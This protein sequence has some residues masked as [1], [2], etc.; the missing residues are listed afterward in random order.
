MADGSILGQQA[1]TLASGNT[2]TRPGTPVIGML[3]YNTQ[4][5]ALENYT[6]NGW[7]KVAVPV[8]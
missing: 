5:D 6:A 8:P 4:T 7:L 3:R 1:I 2:A